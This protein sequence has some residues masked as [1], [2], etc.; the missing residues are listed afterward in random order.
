MV[1]GKL[2]LWPDASPDGVEASETV[3]PAVLPDMDSDDFGGSWYAR[4]MP[5]GVDT[6]MENLAGEE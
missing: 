4:D 1:Q 3:S 5:Y 2:W 6:L